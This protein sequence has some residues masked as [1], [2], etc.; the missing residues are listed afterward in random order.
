MV[1]LTMRQMAEQFAYS[2]CAPNERDAAI[3]AFEAGFQSCKQL[4]ADK[5]EQG[6]M[7][8]W[9]HYKTYGEIQNLGS[10][11]TKY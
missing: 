3:K 9:P 6:N 7:E 11:P 1:G 5:S 2:N 4:A 8:Q 10:D